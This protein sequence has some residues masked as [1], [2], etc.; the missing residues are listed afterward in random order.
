[1]VPRDIGDPRTL[2][3]VATAFGDDDRSMAWIPPG[4]RGLNPGPPPATPPGDRG[5]VAGEIANLGPA[6][7][8][9]VQGDAVV[10]RRLSP[11]TPSTRRRAV[12]AATARR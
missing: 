8:L 3:G 9:F 12:L 5:A 7:A 2:D 10:V 4:P 6:S 11:S 1:M